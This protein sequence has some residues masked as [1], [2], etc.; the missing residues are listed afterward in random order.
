MLL[1]QD[2]VFCSWLERMRTVVHRSGETLATYVLPSRLL[3]L[4]PV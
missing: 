1:W 2:T 3:N 4:A